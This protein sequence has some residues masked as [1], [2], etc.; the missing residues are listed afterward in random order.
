MD[1]KKHQPRQRKIH[2]CSRLVRARK[3][4]RMGKF[5]QSR[6]AFNLQQEHQ[7]NPQ[8]L[9]WARSRALGQMGNRRHRLGSETLGHFLPQSP[10][11]LQ[12]NGAPTDGTGTR[13]HDPTYVASSKSPIGQLRA[14][15][16]KMRGS[17]GNALGKA[18]N[19]PSGD[20]GNL[21]ALCPRYYPA[22][23]AGHNNGCSPRQPSTWRHSKACSPK[24]QG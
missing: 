1:C 11:S 7:A 18:P 19:M 17:Q 12:G 10:G 4:G 3:I 5:I 14:L 15:G 20:G 13:P 8:L 2:A 16:Q 24:W 22:R 21:T 6:Q 23:A 9:V